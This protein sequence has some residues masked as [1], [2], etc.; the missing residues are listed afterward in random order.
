[1]PELFVR[2]HW[3][4]PP[5]VHAAVTTRQSPGVSAAPFDS[6]NLGL[7]SGDNE[8]AVLA[9]RR[10]VQAALVL[11]A[12]PRWLHQ[13]H[14]TLVEQQ[15]TLA[16][17][18]EPQ[19]DAC[20]SRDA[21]VV[22]AVLAADCL[23]VLLCSRDGR[24]IAAAHAGWRGLAAGVL[25]MTLGAMS[26]TPSRVMAWLGP[27]IGA[28]SYEVGDEVR[29]A[30]IASDKQATAA[31]VRTRPGHWHAD[32]AMLARQ[33]LRRAGVSAIYGGGF[34]TAADPRFYSYRRDGVRSGR[35]ASLIWRDADE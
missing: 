8:A 12:A 32:L 30:L 4:V 29:H 13:V 14:G 35:F 1:M 5:G 15:N 2:P 26:T 23:P 31:F 7:R 9:N 25:Q 17:E 28:A 21:G 19:A 33:R 11:P 34:D 10:A 3:P 27:C 22:L 18:S 24:E 16:P 20:V 6:C